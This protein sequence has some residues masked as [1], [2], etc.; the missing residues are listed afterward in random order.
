MR[1]CI[2]SDKAEVEEYLKQSGLP[3]ATV[4]TG[5]LS[6]AGS[7]SFCSF[8]NNQVGSVKTY[9][10]MFFALHSQGARGAD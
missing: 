3:S 8:P 6:C 4:Q 7:H 1:M 5:L 10:S 9:G 2:S